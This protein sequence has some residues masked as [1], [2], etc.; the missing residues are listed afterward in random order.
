MQFRWMGER[1]NIG[2]EMEEVVDTHIVHN[3][4]YKG[5]KVL[6]I[7]ENVSRGEKSQRKYL[8]TF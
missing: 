1:T 5:E 7:K 3:D 8:F 6:D 4:S 2:R